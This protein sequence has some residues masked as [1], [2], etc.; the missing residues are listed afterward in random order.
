MLELGFIGEELNLS[1]VQGADF[2]PITVTMTNPDTTPVDLTGST[3]RGQI[4]TTYGK[5]LA[6]LSVEIDN[7]SSGVYTFG[8]PAA[9]TL[10]LPAGLELDSADSVHVWDLESVNSSGVV[11]PLYYGKVTVRK[12]A[13][14]A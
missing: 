11:M 2:G 9:S 10:K 7:P 6:N 13:T 1:M 3:I 12:R 4:R 5:H 8:V 14:K